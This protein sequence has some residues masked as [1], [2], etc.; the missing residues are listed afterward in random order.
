MQFSKGLSGKTN[1]EHAQCDVIVQTAE[2]LRSEWVKVFREQDETK[3][4]RMKK[5]ILKFRAIYLHYVSNQGSDIKQ[6]A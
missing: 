6:A 1:L 4:V 2:D 5:H 3:R